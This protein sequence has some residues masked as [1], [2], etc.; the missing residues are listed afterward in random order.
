ME[1]FGPGR[2]ADAI[3]D[4][5]LTDPEAD[6]S[7]FNLAADLQRVEVYPEILGE[8]PPRVPAPRMQKVC[9]W[10]LSN[11]YTEDMVADQIGIAKETV[12]EYLKRFR[13]KHN[14]VGAPMPQVIAFALRHQII[15]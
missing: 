8:K 12:K 3:L 7:W 10:Y 1:R 15:P 6:S 4:K 13:L 14:L 9:L 11:G 2:V 5:W